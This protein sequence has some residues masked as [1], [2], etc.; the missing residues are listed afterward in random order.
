MTGEFRSSVKH[1][2]ADRRR[3]MENVE[4]PECGSLNCKQRIFE[5]KCYDCG[6]VIEGDDD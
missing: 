2:K 4:C 6:V 5:I 3:T 1:T